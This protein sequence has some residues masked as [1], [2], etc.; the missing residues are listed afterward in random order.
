MD[1]ETEQEEGAVPV[2]NWNMICEDILSRFTDKELNRY[3]EHLSFNDY[4]D[5]IHYHTDLLHAAET[6][7][8]KFPKQFLYA[9]MLDA[10]VGCL[11]VDF[12]LLAYAEMENVEELSG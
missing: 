5:I 3:L 4:A 2:R 6:P 8:G 7:P 9:A 1:S 11:R 10:T 12:E